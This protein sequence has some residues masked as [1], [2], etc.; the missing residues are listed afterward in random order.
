MRYL[1][2]TVLLAAI[3]LLHGCP[4]VIATGVG[5]AVVTGQ[6]RRTFG[7]ITEDQEIE[8]KAGQRIDQQYPDPHI[9]ITSYNRMVLLTGEAPD[10]AT[11]TGI[12]QT[13]QAVENVRGVY[14]EITVAG[15]SSSP[16]RVNDS[17]LTTKVKTR[18]I[19]E[20]KFNPIYVK[21]VTESGV[22]YLLGLV[23]HDEA[24]AATEIA[25]TTSGVRKVVK[26]F[27]YLD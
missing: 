18:F 4:A 16:A 7:T 27:E 23:K 3:P 6:D 26:L 10:E 1:T 21:V 5:T 24:D 11:R 13:A 12:E 17:Y 8:F 15:N 22:V 20:G 14:D 2:V 19:D 9:N 25:R